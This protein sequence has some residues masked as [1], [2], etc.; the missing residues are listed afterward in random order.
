M[1]RRKLNSSEPFFFFLFL[2]RVSN[3]EEGGGKKRWMGRTLVSRLASTLVALPFTHSLE[4]T[5]MASYP[6]FP[7]F[8][9]FG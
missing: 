3:R 6:G 8:L 4:H 1:Q 9:H 7:C 2:L 5:L